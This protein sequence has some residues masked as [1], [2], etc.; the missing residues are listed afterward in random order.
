L[1]SLGGSIVNL[2]GVKHDIN[3]IVTAMMAGCAAV[4]M[5]SVVGLAAQTSHE[6]HV[7]ADAAKP[8]S[9]MAA[10]NKAMIAEREQ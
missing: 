3:R 7:A 9:G 2:V 6:Q 5:S 1:L 4:V 8:A 10:K